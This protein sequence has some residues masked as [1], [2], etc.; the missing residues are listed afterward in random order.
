MG[1]G[2]TK[3]KEQEKEHASGAK[4]DISF[5]QE[6]KSFTVVWLISGGTRIKP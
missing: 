4:G 5:K 2:K 6:K 3:K 1:K